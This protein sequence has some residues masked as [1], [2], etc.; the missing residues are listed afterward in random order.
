MPI[1]AFQSPVSGR[2]EI[3]YGISM[4]LEATHQLEARANVPALL[5]CGDMSPL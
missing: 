4:I 2:V 5:E 3:V 1:L